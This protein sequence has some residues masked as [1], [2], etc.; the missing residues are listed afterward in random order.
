MAIG[1][2]TSPTFLPS[3]LL[4]VQMP[5]HIAY[6]RN[7]KAP[8]RTAPAAASTVVG[9]STPC[10]KV[11]VAPFGTSWLAKTIGR[12]SI[13]HCGRIGDASKHRVLDNSG[14]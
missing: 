8:L 1:A 2:T 7:R 6:L 13:E 3:Y 5:A 14:K 9:T 10:A 12:R 11:R 4:T